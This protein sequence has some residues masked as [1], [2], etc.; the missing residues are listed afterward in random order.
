MRNYTVMS[1][2]WQY[3][4]GK[5]R[6]LEISF[7]RADLRGTLAVILSVAKDLARRT[8]RSFATLRACPRAER[9]DDRPYLQLSVIRGSTTNGGAC[10]FCTMSRETTIQCRGLI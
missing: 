1:C 6:H 4:S 10:D 7:S 3:L 5:G 8:K 2:A 9:R